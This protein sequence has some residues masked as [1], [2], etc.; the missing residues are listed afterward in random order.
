LLGSLSIAFFN[1]G[2]DS[3]DVGHGRGLPFGGLDCCP[4]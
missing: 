3:G 1:G 4:L 2:E